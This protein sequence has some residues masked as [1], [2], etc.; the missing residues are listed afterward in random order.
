MPTFLSLRRA[1]KGTRKPRWVGLFSS[2]AFS[3]TSFDVAECGRGV[4]PT[5]FV[6]AVLFAGTGLEECFLSLNIFFRIRVY[7]S[8]FIPSRSPGPKQVLCEFPQPSSVGSLVSCKIYVILFSPE[9]CSFSF[10]HLD[11][12]GKTLSALEKHILGQLFIDTPIKGADGCRFKWDE[13]RQHL[14]SRKPGIR[15]ERL[16]RRA[17]CWRIPFTRLLRERHAARC[18]P[19][20]CLARQHVAPAYGPLGLLAFSQTVPPGPGLH[21]LCAGVWTCHTQTFQRSERVV[22]NCT[23]QHLLACCPLSGWW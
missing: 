8:V 21:T 14:K 6:P 1:I 19:A 11:L 10:S 20:A 5:C 23:S 7:T 2:K 16:G 3:I 17:S 9:N 22:G 18:P 12:I 4:Q 13:H 15:R